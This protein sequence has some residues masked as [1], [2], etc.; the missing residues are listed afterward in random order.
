MK[1]LRY[2]AFAAISL[3][4]LTASACNGAAAES[5][6]APVPRDVSAAQLRSVTLN[7]G[8]QKGGTKTLLEASGQLKSLPFKVNF[9]TFTSGPPELEAVNAGAVDVAQV[10]NTPPIFSAAAK[11]NNSV[12]AAIKDPAS[13]DAILTPK[14]STLN[15]VRSLR[16]K[17]I[18]VAK[19][20][21]AHG[22][23]L[24]QLAKAGLS[25]KDVHLSFLQPS[26][27]Y[28]AFTQHRVDAWAIWD[29]YT[30]QA[31]LID[32]ARVLVDGDGVANGLEFQVASRSALADPGKNA[33]I[34]KVVAAVFRAEYWANTHKLQWAQAYAKATGLSVATAGRQA[35][36]GGK[37]PIPLDKSVID[38]EQRLADSFT[39]EKS[40]PG[41]VNFADFVD[42]RYGAKLSTEKEK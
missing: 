30:A 9:S 32:H 17:T 1:M 41:K 24:R 15:G 2:K 31:E 34:E 27:A 10:G 21:S 25:T 3:V 11:S 29:P 39:E 6:K 20:T 19:G 18:A 26:D 14:E 16:G 23:L 40:L 42:N 4:A 36:R 13:G 5:G 28:A 35:D 7:V 22:H 12:V 38:D 33:A 37:F 8:D